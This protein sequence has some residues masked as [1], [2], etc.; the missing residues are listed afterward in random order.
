M[1][2]R[3]KVES[4]TRAN[5]HIYP[6]VVIDT[7]EVVGQKPYGINDESLAITKERPVAFCCTRHT[8]DSFCEQLNEKGF[9]ETI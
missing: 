2:E 6:F 9:I 5:N 4:N 7:R 1:A 8:A 3:Y